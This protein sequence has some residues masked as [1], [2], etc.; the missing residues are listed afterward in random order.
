[1]GIR[2]RLLLLLVGLGMIPAV[3]AQ[4]WSVKEQMGIGKAMFAVW[5]PEG[6]FFAIVGETD[7]RFYDLALQ[8]QAILWISR[9]EAAAWHP[10]GD[11]LALG[12]ADGSISI[13]DVS[14]LPEYD[15]VTSIDHARA[16]FVWSPDGAQLAHVAGNGVIRIWDMATERS[17]VVFD[18]HVSHDEETPVQRILWTIDGTTIVSTSRD[19]LAIWDAATGDLQD[20]LTDDRLDDLWASL[21]Q[22]GSPPE[23]INEAARRVLE[24]V[25]INQPYHELNLTTHVQAQAY[26]P[27]GEWLAVFDEYQDV[28]LYR[29]TETGVAEVAKQHMSGIPGAFSYETSGFIAWNA[30]SN[31]LVTAT[32]ATVVLW[33]I[34]GDTLERVGG[35]LD[36]NGLLSSLDFSPDGSQLA[37]GYGVPMGDYYGADSR[38]RIWDVVSGD[39]VW[40]SELDTQNTIDVAWWHTNPRYIAT[41][42]TEDSC[43]VRVWDL[44]THE[45][46]ECLPGIDGEIGWHPTEDQL[47]VAAD[48]RLY[49]LDP[50]NFPAEEDLQPYRPEWQDWMHQQHDFDWSP[51]GTAIVSDGHPKREDSVVIWRAADGV[52]LTELED[53]AMYVQGP[54]GVPYRSHHV[55]FSPDGRWVAVAEGDV[56]HWA[57]ARYNISIAIYDAATGKRTATLNGH[58]AGITAL[59]WSPDSRILVSGSMDGTARAW[60]VSRPETNQLLVD[61]EFPIAAVDWSP[62]DDVIAVGTEQ[63]IIY[64]LQLR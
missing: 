56:N 33:H 35:L 41:A 28:R 3:S 4:Y 60:F 37:A 46:I 38:L 18:G 32:E 12:E 45:I 19:K 48:G 21:Q 64:L 58:R 52:L 55:K 2:L 44:Q 61:S 24:N 51:D 54:S 17:E 62:V 49:L 50:F 23:L 40:R 16:P 13:W 57:G 43:A 34:E 47:M 11:L 1:M 14:N 20:E 5:Q 25:S 31:Y 30:A 22:T 8:E 59:A 26:S 10:S 6:E 27:D 15:F 7:V 9:V 63:G 36:Y 29:I 39:L 42:H 53:S